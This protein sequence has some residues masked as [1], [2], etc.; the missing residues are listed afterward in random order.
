MKKIFL[1]VVVGFI[2]A[3]SV[4][5]FASPAEIY[6]DVKGE[7]IRLF[8][9]DDELNVKIGAESGEGANI[10]GTIVLYN[11]AN[12]EAE[13]FSRVALG[14]L[15]DTDSGILQIMN[16]NGIINT[17]LTTTEGYIGNSRIA[18][19]QWLNNN[20]YIKKSDV[21]KMINEAVKNLK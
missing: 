5:V 6:D 11:Y 18:T 1:G 19:E 2:L 14:T 12:K 15:K 4:S 16:Y 9:A 3:F 13:D 21:Q 8:N 7:V 10:G 20:G 17:W